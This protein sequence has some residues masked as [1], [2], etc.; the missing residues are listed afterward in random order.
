MMANKAGCSGRSMVEMLGVLAIIGVLTIGGISMYRYSIF[1]Q[2]ANELVEAMNVRVMSALNADTQ[3]GDIAEA[4]EDEFGNII[5][6]RYPMSVDSIT[7]DWLDLVDTPAVVASAISKEIC[8]ILKSTDYR[9]DITVLINGTLPIYAECRETADNQLAFAIDEL[10]VRH[11]ETEDDCPVCMQCDTTTSLCKAYECPNADEGCNPDSLKRHDCVSLCST[12]D[13]CANGEICQNGLC[14]PC[15]SKKKPNDAR[16]ACVC[17]QAQCLGN[18]FENAEPDEDCNCTCAMGVDID[19]PDM[20]TCPKGQILLENE[21]GK[22]RCQLAGN[23]RKKGDGRFV[24][25]P[26]NNDTQ[27]CGNDCVD[28]S[29]AEG[30]CNGTCEPGWCKATL[31]NDAGEFFSKGLFGNGCSKDGARCAPTHYGKVWQCFDGTQDCCRTN[32]SGWADSFGVD[33]CQ[34]G[35]CDSSVCSFDGASYTAMSRYTSGCA[36]TYNDKTVYCIPVSVRGDSDDSWDWI[37]T[38][39]KPNV[40]GNPPA[41]QRCGSCSYTELKKGL[42]GACS[43]C[44]KDDGTN[45]CLQAGQKV[46]KYKLKI[47]GTPVDGGCQYDYYGRTVW[48]ANKYCYLD[49]E[50][51]KDPDPEKRCCYSGHQHPEVCT[52]GRCS[53]HTPEYIARDVDTNVVSGDCGGTFAG[54]KVTSVYYWGCVNGTADEGEKF[55]LDGTYLYRRCYYQTKD[56]LGTHKTGVLCG[57]DCKAD[58]SVCA[59]PNDSHCSPEATG[60]CSD[61]NLEGCNPCVIYLGDKT[62]QEVKIGG[63][64]QCVCPSGYHE[65]GNH[66]CANGL[67]YTGSMC[68]LFYCSDA[69]TCFSDIQCKTMTAS[70]TRLSGSSNC[71]CRSSTQCYDAPVHACKNVG[72]YGTGDYSYTIMKNNEGRCVYSCNEGLIFDH[73]KLACVEA[74]SDEDGE[75]D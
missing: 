65:T 5:V 56:K 30:S 42:D 3:G 67:E 72:S 37:C 71:A 49:K 27:P 66:C 39:N 43:N 40:R 51:G 62:S 47:G 53:S 29:G 17:I 59:A 31:G 28:A 69:G 24:C 1:K 32:G 48:C 73:E 21:E 46:N 6:D 12:A 54:R 38:W 74:D 26:P 68:Q 50:A 34:Y 44:W 2:Q 8:S 18:A 11:C 16:D 23:C 41:A 75:E 14:K 64:R 20:C 7:I 33:K 10:S 61:D 45:T 15:P 4:L 13:D 55:Y 52:I 19:S 58:C 35:T 22:L 57:K 25:Y 63:V 9:A 70:M 60:A 36:V